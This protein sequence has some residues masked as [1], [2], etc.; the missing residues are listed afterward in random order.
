[1][2]TLTRDQILRAAL[3]KT[4]TLSKGEPP[5]SDELEEATQALELTLKD[6][7]SEGCYLWTIEEFTFD[8]I[9]G[10]E[11]YAMPANTLDLW[12]LRARWSNTNLDY[13]VE[14]VSHARWAEFYDVA[15]KKRMRPGWAR[16]DQRP[17]DVPAQLDTDNLTVLAPAIVNSKIMKLYRVPDSVYTMVMWR[18]RELAETTGPNA[19][20]DVQARWY[21]ALIYGVAARLADELTLPMERCNWLQQKS[22]HY[23]KIARGGAREIRDNRFLAP[24]YP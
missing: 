11:T 15:L 20:V 23:L 16:F 1:M 4:G 19:S 6:M 17:Q 18:I 10:V 7:Q 2:L 8:T 24:A 3:R 22:E 5:A 9:G 13:P 21:S 12:S 14:L